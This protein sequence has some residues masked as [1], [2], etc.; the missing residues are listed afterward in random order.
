M[1]SDDRSTE[2]FPQTFN[3]FHEFQNTIIQKFE[4][5]GV[6][7]VKKLFYRISISVLHDGVKYDSF[8]IGSD[9]DLQVLIHCCRYFF[10]A[11]TPELLTKLV[12]VVSSSRSSN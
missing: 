5:H 4:L 7:R 12:D 2:C 8:V 1:A 6:K 9:G 3:E 10:E 11:R